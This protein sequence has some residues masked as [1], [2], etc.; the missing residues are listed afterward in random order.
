MTHPMTSQDTL[1]AEQRETNRLLR[2]I[3]AN[4]DALLGKPPIHVGWAGAELRRMFALIDGEYRLVNSDA[5][6]LER[7]ER[8][9]FVEFDG[10]Y[11][12]TPKGEAAWKEC[13][14]R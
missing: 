3:A 5:Q 11:Q 4:L 6:M 9:H 2:Q 14:K 10:R 1:L 7:L 12:M 13:P 8:E